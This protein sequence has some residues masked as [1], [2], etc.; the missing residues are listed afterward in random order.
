MHK[1]LFQL[2]I[3]YKSR[4][5]LR[6]ICRSF[7][8][9]NTDI[10]VYRYTYIYCMITADPSDRILSD[11]DLFDIN[12]RNAACNNTY[13]I[14]IENDHFG[15]VIEVSMKKRRRLSLIR[16]KTKIDIDRFCWMRNG[17]HW[18]T[19]SLGQIV[20]GKTERDTSATI[21]RLS[22]SLSSVPTYFARFTTEGNYQWYVIVKQPTWLTTIAIAKEDR[23]L[24]NYSFVEWRKTCPKSSLL[25]LAW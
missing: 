21:N 9:L 10:Y 8:Y 24:E 12:N 19:C 6:T 17:V 18:D 25:I 15:R 23:H 3:T 4:I 5:L 7:S 13:N 11:T 22:K 16:A 2:Q 20:G 1:R 14:P